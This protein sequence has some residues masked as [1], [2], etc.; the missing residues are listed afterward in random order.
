VDAHHDKVALNRGALRDLGFNWSNIVMATGPKSL[1]KAPN[2][3]LNSSFLLPRWC[4]LVL[5]LSVFVFTIYF[6]VE[7]ST[8]QPPPHYYEFY[9]YERNLPQH[10]P[11]LPA[12]EGMH[13]KFFWV[14]NHVGS[15]HTSHRF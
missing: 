14:K 4:S 7:F 6:F 13:A 15:T 5:L 8:R 9:E 10:N 11:D 3:N 2:V 1:P 12:P